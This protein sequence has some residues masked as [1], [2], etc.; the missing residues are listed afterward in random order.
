MAR[1][2]GPLSRKVIVAALLCAAVAGCGL[3]AIEQRAAW[4]GQ[5]EEACLA[6][7]QVQASAYVQPMRAMSGPGVC[8]MDHPFRVTAFAEGSVT[9]TSRATLA[10]PAISTTDRWLAEIVQP[11]AML[12]FGSPVAKMNAG[13]YSCRSMNNQAGASR[14]E[15]SYGNAVDIMSLRLV[16]GRVIDVEKGWRGAPAEQEFLREIFVGACRYFSTVLAPGSD[17]F[18]YNHLHLDLARHAKGRKICKPIL[19]FTPRIDPD[20]PTPVYDPQAVSG[21]GGESYPMT[22]PASGIDA[23]DPQLP[24]A[25]ELEG[26][27]SHDH[28]PL[29]E[30]PISLAPAASPSPEFGSPPQRPVAARYSPSPVPPVAPPVRSWGDAGLRPPGLVGR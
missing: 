4:R 2:I 3:F 13:S 6:S 16:D 5:A 27:T 29:E 12:Y 7:R 9:L 26:M 14:S 8:G 19:K 15:H 17:R 21:L 28:G 24:A 23:A 1:P 10:C 30:A 22:Q 20:N 11:A 18:H 25:P